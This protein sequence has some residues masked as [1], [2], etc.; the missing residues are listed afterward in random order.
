MLSSLHRHTG[1]KVL[2]IRLCTLGTGNSFLPNLLPLPPFAKVGGAEK[3]RS[4][5]F[6]TNP[7]ARHLGQSLCESSFQYGRHAQDCGP[8]G[9]IE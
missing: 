9:V 2:Y 1:I 6:H 4:A 7:S 5:S 8:W 3:S